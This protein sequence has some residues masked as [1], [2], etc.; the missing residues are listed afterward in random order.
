MFTG[1]F[2]RTVDDKL[3]VPIPKEL[4]TQLRLAKEQGLYVAPGT[5]GSLV[6][7]TEEEFSK[8][9]QRL[10]HSPPTQKDVR[11]FGRL[12]YGLARRATLDGQ[13]RVRIP[14]ELAERAGINKEVMLVGVQDHIELWDRNAWET[15]LAARLEQYDAIAEAAFQAAQGRGQDA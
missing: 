8:L 6:L 14:Q 5:D 13:G 10:A 4:R 7:Y 1:S 15:Y 11:A 2:G 12:F 9:A 3:R